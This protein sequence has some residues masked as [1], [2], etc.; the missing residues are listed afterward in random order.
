MIGKTI[1]HYNVLEKLGR[2][3][4][5]V[6]YKAEDTKL[7]RTVALKFLPPQ[8]LATDEEKSRFIREAQAAASLDHPNIC[9]VYE[10]NEA[11][12]Q[13]FI[14]IAYIEGE[15][16][17]QKIKSGLEID[18]AVDIAIQIADGLRAAHEKEIVHRDIKSANIM[19]TT[20]GRAIIMD[21][22]LAKLSTQTQLTQLGTTL[23]TI[24]YMSPEQGRVED[25]DHRSDIWSFGVVLYE[26]LSGKLPFE[27]AYEQAVI[28]SI[29]NEEPE[30]LSTLRTDMP[31]ELEAI[32][33]KAMRKNP[34]E[35]YQSAEEMLL[36]LKAFKRG[37]ISIT[38][39]IQKR[40]PKKRNIKKHV[41]WGAA[42]LLLVFIFIAT[43]FFWPL[44]KTT[45]AQASIAVLPFKDMSQ[46]KDQ[47]YF[48]EG[49]TEELITKLGKIE[50]MKVIARTSIMRYKNTDKSIKEIGNALDVANI[51]EGSIRKE[52]DNV[53]VAIKLINVED[54][55]HIWSE[56]YNKKLSG[57]FELQSEVAGAIAEALQIKLTSNK[58]LE[59]K[60]AEPKNVEAYE[61]YLKGMYQL[62]RR[63]VISESEKA[64]YNALDMFNKAIDI[65]SS[66][67]LAYVGLGAAYIHQF[68]ASAYQNQEALALAKNNYIHA[69]QLDPNS[70]EANAGIS[71]IHSIEGDFDNAYQ[72][73]RTSIK[74]NP[75]N[76]ETDF[77]SAMLLRNRG[78]F[79]ESIRFFS[80]AKDLNPFYVATYTNMAQDLIFIGK[81][82]QASILL[83]KAKE[84]EPEFVPI[85]SMEA[86]LAIITTKYDQ[87]E[88]I[89]SQAEKI[90]PGRIA[91]EKALL[92]AA[93]GEKEKALSFSSHPVFFF[94]VG[95]VYAL[96]G[97][98][99]K[100]IQEII[101][102]NSQNR[103]YY[104]YLNLINN[105]LLR[106]LGGDPR[107][108]KFVEEQK[109][110]HEEY[111]QKYGDL[112]AEA[113]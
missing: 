6:V 34:S 14:S 58:T 28:Y 111:L 18:E 68:D 79:H 84:I 76:A 17:K 12:D 112:V 30:S 101:R 113:I 43:N 7:K 5:G 3:G 44:S 52:G 45:K 27:A 46:Q 82:D 61:Y 24:A 51:L 95:E 42:I 109:Q 35:R 96:L 33:K 21:F 31:E 2:G 83:K 104:Y 29:M 63:Y 66:Y 13:T 8:A 37:E 56:D 71:I 89:I 54:E 88:A 87:A 15:E 1:S 40:D 70:A 67:A 62:N 77:R 97:M 78:L 41:L 25:V 103:G 9:T 19:V 85:H 59:F 81:Y 75:N 20:N 105:P 74:L 80:K 102:E 38:A 93:R 107:F 36:E 53:R 110:K 47:E 11:D 16:L 100:A 106:N 22:G 94:I 10:I 39:V 60:A 55:S 49:M 98:K 91:L 90:H 50:E 48:C 64:L 108:L 86:Q 32:V 73:L 57:I 92:H 4:M 72:S 99:D 65:E 23:G 69:L 26:M